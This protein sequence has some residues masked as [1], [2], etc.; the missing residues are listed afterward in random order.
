MRVVQLNSVCGVGSTGRIV[1]DIQRGLENEGHEGYVFYGRGQKS[2]DDRHVYTGSR[3]STYAH[4]ALTRLLDRHG[5][6][7]R[8]ATVHLVT[9][10]ESL[11]ANIIHLHNIHGYYVNIDVLFGYLRAAGKPLIWTLHDCWAFTG[12]CSYFDYVGC[13]KWRTGCFGCPQKKGYPASFLLDNSRDNYRLKKR[14]FAGL[15]R[16]TI[17]TPSK[18]L[19]DLVAES[20]LGQYP[21]EVINN[22]IDTERF[23]PVRGSFRSKY[24]IEDRFVILGVASVWDRR[25]GLQYLIELSGMLGDAATIVIVGLTERQKRQLPRRMIGVTRTHS[26]DELVEIYSCADVFVNPTLEDNFPTTNLEAMACG[27][28]VV[29]FDTGGSAESLG[30]DCGVVVAQKE[31]SALMSA[32]QTI[33]TNGKGTYLAHCL[34]RVRDRFNRGSMTTRYLDLYHRVV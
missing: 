6:G 33:K 29:T 20:F 1:L 27:T 34:K 12:H 11:D 13:E 21:V 22:G 23:R 9:Q 4:V 10:I 2:A 30:T 31:S 5:L 26:V 8:L 32:I 19:R 16:T 24:G 18:W 7:S 25:K 14:L 3:F 15:D 17:V 28:P